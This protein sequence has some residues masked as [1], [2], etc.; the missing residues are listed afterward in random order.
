[1][2]RTTTLVKR[3]VLPT[4]LMSAMGLAVAQKAAPA[5]PAA[6]APAPK[7]PAPPKAAPIVSKP[8]AAPKAATTTTVIPAASPAMPA[9]RATNLP[10]AG[11]H[12]PIKMG[13]PGRWWDDKKFAKNIGITQDQQKRMDDAFAANRATLVARYESLREAQAKLDAV[14]HAAKPPEGAVFTEIDRVAQARAELEKVNTHML[15]Q[16]R[17]EL[18]PD[19]IGKLE[20]LP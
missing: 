10:G 19:Q 15:L 4:L 14:S 13:P 20:E 11:T 8:I 16:I 5:P 18:T 1:M 3:L 9:Y 12:G 6:K 7:A 2:N 17:S